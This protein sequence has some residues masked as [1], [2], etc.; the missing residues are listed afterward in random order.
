M[1]C[2]G[3]GGWHNPGEVSLRLAEMRASGVSRPDAAEW[4]R[5]KHGHSGF[6]DF[7]TKQNRYNL[8]QRAYK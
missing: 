7:L 8:L 4:L 1:Q 2:F 5:E 6:D 3:R